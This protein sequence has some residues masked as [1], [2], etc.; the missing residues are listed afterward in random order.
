MNTS[1]AK[2]STAPA[3][4]DDREEQQPPTSDAA[5]AVAQGGS[6][7]TGEKN[8]PSGPDALR[9]T[10]GS[11][12]AENAEETDEFEDLEESLDEEDDDAAS[13][14]VG[15]GAGAVV[16]AALG[17]VG[18]V[19]GWT[20]KVASERE[21]LIGQIKTS[22]GGSTAQQISEIYGD[23][24]HTTALV[25]G[26]FA[27][28]ALLVGVYV[29]VR[30]AFGA[31]SAKPQPSWIRSVALG[32]VVLGAIGLVLSIAMFFDLIVGLPSA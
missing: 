31:P 3:A 25:N 24:W 8:V 9:K 18:L 21:T 26:I 6:P 30:P 22:G 5:D 20:G 28:V 15:A 16:S 29:L 17:V 27:I 2:T 4:E 10:D 7:A 13:R 32:G 1:T 12:N 11:E 23:S 19:G 14:G